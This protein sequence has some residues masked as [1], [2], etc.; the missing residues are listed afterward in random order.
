MRGNNGETQSDNF[1]YGRYNSEFITTRGGY[2]FWM[3][4]K[5]ND[6]GNLEEIDKLFHLEGDFGNMQKECGNLRNL[7]NVADVE[8][9]KG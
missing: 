2:Y 3:F 4:R 9:E 1:G 7:E 5:Q 6:F 8:E